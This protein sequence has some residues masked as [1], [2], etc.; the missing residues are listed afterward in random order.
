MH[1]VASGAYGGAEEH[2]RVLLPGLVR[3]GW[4]VT[5]AAPRESALRGRLAETGVDFA[6]WGPFHAADP[7]APRDLL[8]LLSPEGVGRVIL[9]GHNPLED[10]SV[11]AARVIRGD[12]RA[13][14]TIHDRVAMDSRGRRRRDCNTSAYRAVL[15]LGFDRILAVSGA[16]ARD[17]AAFAGLS[18]HRITAIANGTDFSRIDAAPSRAEARR[19][20]GIP[21]GAFVFGMAARVETLAHRKKGVDTFLAAARAVLADRPAARAWVVGLGPAALIQARDLLTGFQDRSRVELSPFR[22]DLPMLLSAWDVAVLP[23][24]FEGLPR[25]VVEAMAMG[26][27]VVATAVDGVVE[28]LTSEAGILVPPGDARALARAIGNLADDP[29]RA[30]RMGHAGRLRARARY[31][32]DRMVADVD[33]VYREIA[34]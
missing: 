10:M 13:L 11:F 8:R 14:T 15:R 7:W 27:P 3:R 20:L 29:D 6:D 32:A 21:D 16:T 22:T 4:R 31:G 1:L 33:A 25:G 26:K 19:T 5:L 24:L 18:P 12:V 30:M 34:G 9:H 2:V 23:S 17:A 28:I